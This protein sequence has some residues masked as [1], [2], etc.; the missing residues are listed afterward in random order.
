MRKKK[1]VLTSTKEK[2]IMKLSCDA[3]YSEVRVGKGQM[4]QAAIQ[5]IGANLKIKPSDKIVD[6]LDICSARGDFAM[7]ALEH[8]KLQSIDCVDPDAYMTVSYA[9]DPRI[10]LTIGK[11]ADL[12]T[13]RLYDLVYSCHSL[14]HYRD[15]AKKL[16]FLVEHIKPNRYLL[17]DVPNI[18]TITDGHNVD[19]FFYDYHR[20]Y[21]NREILINYV[22]HL[23]MELVSQNNSIYSIMLLVKKT[24]VQTT[25]VSTERYAEY[26]EKV[27]SEYQN[28]LT[29]NRSKLPVIAEAMR[30]LAKGNRSALFGCGRVLDAMITYGG[31]DLDHF[32]FLVDN[33][34]KRTTDS[35]YR[36]KLY[37]ASVLD[38]AGVDTI[39]LL[40]R[41]STGELKDALRKQY[42]H[43]TLVHW[44]DLCDSAV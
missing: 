22:S 25:T 13:N 7:L 31:L 19:E 3:D 39:F 6:V 34:L 42:P 41:S 16:A 20:Y 35:L 38:K 28:N 17:L 10:R 32:Q 26:N 24:G 12:K 5:M 29:Y 27:I 21:F 30:H 43:V 40:T 36:K 1:S 23:G 44:S 4:A 9:H 33:F 8:L 18:E 2:R 15:P 37:D 11:Y 14:E